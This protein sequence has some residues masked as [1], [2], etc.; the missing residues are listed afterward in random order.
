MIHCSP[1]N[2]QPWYTVA[3]TIRLTMIHCSPNHKT[4]R[5]PIVHWPWWWQGVPGSVRWA[6]TQSSPHET[7]T[8][9]VAASEPRPWTY[10]SQPA[11]LSPL[12]ATPEAERAQTLSHSSQTARSSPLHRYTENT[13][14]HANSSGE[15]WCSVMSINMKYK[16]LDTKD[17]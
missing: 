2:Y 1:N 17:I 9:A 4:A 8:L 7:R 14:L 3:P 16:H 12:A 10:P 5:S 11:V 15:K 6:E 13:F